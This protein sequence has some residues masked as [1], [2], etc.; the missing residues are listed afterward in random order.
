MQK[1]LLSIVDQ[2]FSKALLFQIIASTKAL[3]CFC[4]GAPACCKEC[5][6]SVLGCRVHSCTGPPI[7]GMVSRKTLIGPHGQWQYHHVW[8][9]AAAATSTAPLACRAQ[10][11]VLPGWGPKEC[12]AHWG[13]GP[14]CCTFMGP[15]LPWAACG[16]VQ[17]S[18]WV[19]A[20]LALTKGDPAA[21]QAPLPAPALCTSSPPSLVGPVHVE[22]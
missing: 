14:L 10:G 22:H 7:A 8:R 12:A 13:V 2:Q 6:R 15:V 16:S 1:T 5:L 9:L 20:A 19:W 21:R 3:L 17:L 18:T 4:Y 11:R